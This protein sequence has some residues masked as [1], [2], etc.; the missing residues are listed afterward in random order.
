M[1][2]FE[3][4]RHCIVLYSSIV[5]KMVG[6]EV[7]LDF[8]RESVVCHRS[9]KQH[10]SVWTT[11]PPT[12]D[13]YGTRV[14]FL[15]KDLMPIDDPDLNRELS[16]ETIDHSHELKVQLEMLER[17]MMELDKFSKELDKVVKEMKE[18]GV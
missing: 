6:A 4:G 12:Y 10:H 5:P 18:F 14:G 2:K 11:T 3:K 1:A 13:Y 17:S 9:K 15:Q 7:V 8:F 16:V